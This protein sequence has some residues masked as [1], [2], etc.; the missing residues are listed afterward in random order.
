MT[1]TARGTCSL[2]P[3]RAV[4]P[5]ILRDEQEL[6]RWI[7]EKEEVRQ[8]EQHACIR[9]RRH[10]QRGMPGMW[11]AGLLGQACATLRT[12]Q[13]KFSKPYLLQGEFPTAQHTPPTISCP[14]PEMLLTCRSSLSFLRPEAP[15][16]LLWTPAYFY[17]P[18]AWPVVAHSP[19]FCLPP[20]PPEHTGSCI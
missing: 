20:W 8:T 9:I 10:E 1:G 3:Q 4:P 16:H 15:L 18:L 11:E 12:S 2:L 19:P 17:P 6:T 14:L 7:Q 13:I 5:W